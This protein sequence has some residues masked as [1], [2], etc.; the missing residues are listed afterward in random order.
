MKMA[1]SNLGDI[2]VTGASGVIGA[3]IARRLGTAGYPLHLTARDPGKLRGLQ[4]ELEKQG[5]T[6]ATYALNL[7]KPEDPERV[8]SEFFNRAP[9]PYGLVCN[10]GNFGKLGQFIDLTIAEWLQGL[11]ENFIAQVRLIHAF[12]KA[13][14]SRPA[15]DRCI[16]VLSGAGL[17]ANTSFEF[18]S[19]Y[20]TSKAALTHLVEALAPELAKVHTRIN[21][22]S[23]GQVSSGLT[24]TAIRA[25]V[26][27][28]GPYALS[29]QK[30]KETGG[31]SPDLAAQLIEILFSPSSRGITGRLLSARFDRD[32]LQQNSP[33]VEKDPNLFRLR[34]IDNALFETKS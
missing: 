28:A 21:A 32:V 23:P 4:T 9:Q 1:R 30:C 34:R 19:S 7:S 17:G 10:A 22:I 2:L 33:E 31:V 24:E 29:A 5:M 26:E 16:L 15:T 6:V 20:S 18:L 13:V 12:G 25:G 8:I 27:R 11:Q 3:A 14:K